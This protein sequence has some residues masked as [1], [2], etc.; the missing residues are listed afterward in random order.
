MLNKSIPYYNVIMRYDG[1]LQCTPPSVPENYFV[2]G[3]RYGDELRWA[4]MEVLNNDF[5]TFEN[6]VKYFMNRYLVERD[7]LLDRFIGVRNH[8]GKLVGAV[9]CWNDVRNDE[10]VSTVHWLIT[11][12][13]IQGKGIGTFL[14]R[15]LVYKFS[16]LKALP[17]YLHTQPWSYTAVGIYSSIGFKLLKTDSFR[18]Y[19]NQSKEALPILKKYMKKAQYIK[20]VNEMI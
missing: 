13:E 9:I 1:P 6:G 4:Q 10:S 5:D 14:V 2:T 18:G 15:M 20:L 17:I 3:Y 11:D 19:T 16:E 7:K 12:P 8:E